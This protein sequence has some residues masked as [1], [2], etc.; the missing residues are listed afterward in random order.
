MARGVCGEHS[1]GVGGS[2]NTGS[3][4]RNHGG[5]EVGH[6]AELLEFVGE[7]REDKD[8]EREG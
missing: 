7:R 1:V 5:V 8:K 2:T 3:L 6:Q 4:A